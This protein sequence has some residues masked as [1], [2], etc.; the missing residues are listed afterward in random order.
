MKARIID[1]LGWAGVL[2]VAAPIV[3]LL[4]ALV[5]A[6]QPAPPAAV[7]VTSSQ[8][9]TCPVAPVAG[10]VTAAA[11]QGR[12]TTAAVR[13]G[14]AAGPSVVS[15]TPGQLV[16]AA[17]LVAGS[18]QQWAA[19]CT[20]GVADA[21]LVTPDASITDLYLVN[22]EGTEAAVNLT[23][24]GPAGEILDPGA[25]GIV[26]AARTDR[27]VPLSVL[28]PV[29]GPV[30]VR[31]QT[32]HGRVSPYLRVSSPDGADFGSAGTAAE[33]ALL[34]GVPAGASGVSVLLG[35]PGTDRARVTIDSLTSRGRVGLA[36]GAVEVPAGRTVAVD[37]SAAVA[38]EAVSLVVTS[39]TALATGV[40]VAKGG[41]IALIC[42]VGLAD[43]LI[44]VAPAGA[45]LQ[46]AN[47]G[48]QEVT[49]QITP[50]S[51]VPQTRGL[52]AGSSLTVPVSSAGLVQVSGPV[53]GALLVPG[54]GVGLLP[55]QPVDQDGRAIPLVLSPGLGR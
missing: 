19:P 54:P 16:A 21:W 26:L 24:I 50:G 28:A 47:P 29:K 33:V 6:R 4:V 39:S 46:V 10:T 11:D 44:Q 1:R 35:N 14:A 23:L 45:Q 25:R 15:G 32:D 48:Q 41:D 5:P 8:R 49:V 22:A 27:V 2:M 30:S 20:G 40:R 18:V 34:P 43:R 31:V 52:A 53:I 38:G 13:A 42:A 37:L 17:Q 55:M 3:A 51:G 7:Q 12:P 9:L 36:G